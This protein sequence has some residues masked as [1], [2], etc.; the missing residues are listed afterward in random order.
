M[1]NPQPQRPLPDVRA[2]GEER[3]GGMTPADR[4]Q[5]VYERQAS[6][7]LSCGAYG[8]ERVGF[9]IGD[10]VTW[11]GCTGSGMP[12]YDA[13]RAVCI[14]LVERWNAALE[15]PDDPR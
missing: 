2:T 12:G 9:R 14:A 4:A 13:E 7:D 10:R 3:Q 15:A 1:K 8:Y 6:F 5:V 11:M